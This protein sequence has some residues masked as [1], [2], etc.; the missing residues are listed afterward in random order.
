MLLKS[1]LVALQELFLPV[2]LAS[3]CLAGF[4]IVLARLTIRQKREGLTP[5]LLAFGF[6]GGVSGLMAGAS[7]E[8]LVGALLTGLLGLLSG[9]LSY[10]FGKD[11]LKEW[12]P[13]I[14]YSIIVLVLSAL[15]GVSIGGT[16]KAKWES[17][18]RDY[19]KWLLQ[20][21]HVYLEVLKEQQL[22]AV[23]QAAS[24]A[25]PPPPQPTPSQPLASR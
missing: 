15:A 2:V 12:R 1:L 24:V 16:Y 19:K 9:L 10:L 7:R 18:D 23:R 20:Y 11:T 14:P 6:L 4:F 25:Q 13:F 21:E 17:F 22:L 8:S 5:F 3:T